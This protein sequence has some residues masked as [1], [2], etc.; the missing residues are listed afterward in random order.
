MARTT[1]TDSRRYPTG[2]EL[3]AGAAAQ[4]GLGEFGPGDFREGLDRLLDSLELDGDLSPATD[5]DVIGAL[6]RRLVNRLEVEAW[7][8]DHPEIEQLP[9]RGPID[10]NGM[11]RTGT[12]ALVSDVVAGST[13]PVPARL[14]AVE[15]VPPPTLETEATDPRRLE[16]LAEQRRGVAGA[17][18]EAHSSTPTRPWRTP[19]CSAWRSTASSSRCPC[20]ATTSGGATPT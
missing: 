16:L 13:V 3:L 1:S 7:Y 5:D 17:R 10:I 6:R 14:G 4:R 19:S 8:A 11:P 20:S 12:T 18:G 15:S 9:L 2:D